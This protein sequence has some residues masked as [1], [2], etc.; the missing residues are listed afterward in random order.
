MRGDPPPPHPPTHPQTLRVDPGT[1]PT[2]KQL[3][4]RLQPAAKH[5]QPQQGNQQ[6]G[7]QLK[8]GEGE[9]LRHLQAFLQEVRT[10]Y[11]ILQGL[12]R[13]GG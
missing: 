8:G 9:A 7:A 12:M 2:L 6:G 4:L 5:Q 13:I 10:A 11:C 1:I 3:G